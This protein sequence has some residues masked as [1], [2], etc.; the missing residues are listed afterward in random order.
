MCHVVLQMKGEEKMKIKI[1]KH[2]ALTQEAIDKRSMELEDHVARIEREIERQGMPQSAID[3]SCLE[4]EERELAQ[5][6]ERVRFNQANPQKP[7]PEFVEFVAIYSYDEREA[8]KAR[9]YKF[10]READMSDGLNPVA[11]WVKKIDVPRNAEAIGQIADEFDFLRSLG[12]EFS[13]RDE[14]WRGKLDAIISA[15]KSKENE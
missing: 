9:G 3:R 8:L 13:P 15:Y 14:Q 7:H 12:G 11:G 5:A 6:R 1:E 4:R 10:N 2:A